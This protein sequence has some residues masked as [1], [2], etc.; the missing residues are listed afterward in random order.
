[1]RINIEC[2]FGILVRK[3]LILSKILNCDLARAKDIINVCAI[4]HNYT[5]RTVETTAT[6]AEAAGIPAPNNSSTGAD[7]EPHWGNDCCDAACTLSHGSAVNAHQSGLRQS[8]TD[9][10]FR[11]GMVRPGAAPALCTQPLTTNNS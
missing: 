1:M 6:S 4:L 7:T 5:L 11:N 2:A 8:L 10:L 9:I 3:W